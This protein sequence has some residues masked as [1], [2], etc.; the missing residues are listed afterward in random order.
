MENKKNGNNTIQNKNSNTFEYIFKE[1]DN[2][3]KNK[4]NNI[5]LELYNS[6][7]KKHNLERQQ[8]WDKQIIFFEKN[9]QLLKKKEEL[10]QKKK[11]EEEKKRKKDEYEQTKEFRQKQMEGLYLKFIKDN[12]QVNKY[13]NVKSKYKENK[14]LILPKLE[15]KKK[16]GIVPEYINK[17]K[18]EEKE[19]RESENLKKKIS[20]LPKGTIIMT[21][22]EYNIKLNLL[23]EEKKNL[24]NELNN[25]PIANKSNRILKRES[26][27]NNILN[28]IDNEIEKMKKKYLIYILEK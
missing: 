16:I 11:K 8:N 4:S 27:I 7:I 1:I 10:N 9:K 21:E 2:D 3:N 13:S 14:N 18:K 26:E 23:E 15:N 28:D 20:K 24:M 6:Q 25:L 17:Y 22:N 5:Y 19:K 12:K